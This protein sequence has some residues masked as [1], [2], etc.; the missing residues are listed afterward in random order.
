MLI[1][2]GNQRKRKILVIT[3]VI[4]AVLLI[5]IV[6][7]GL[8][9]YFAYSKTVVSAKVAADSLKRQDLQAFK[10]ALGPVRENLKQTQNNFKFF[11]Y[12]KPVPFLSGYYNDGQH[13]FKAAYLGLDTAEIAI[14]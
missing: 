11:V 7:P 3:A 9:V 13:L 14:D 4:I 12:L 1:F 6:I 10:S 2:Y 5:L 8:R